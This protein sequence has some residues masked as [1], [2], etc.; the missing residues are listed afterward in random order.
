MHR[1]LPNFY[2]S[3]KCISGSHLIVTFLTNCLFMD[4]WEDTNSEQNCSWFNIGFTLENLWSRQNHLGILIF[5]LFLDQCL[6]QS[7]IRSVLQCVFWW[8]FH[9]MKNTGM[10]WMSLV[11]P[12]VFLLLP[13]RKLLEM[14]AL[15]VY[16]S[17]YMAFLWPV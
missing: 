4:F 11:R 1:I 8:N 14:V 12:N 3:I 13:L 5:C 6:L 2:F 7:I 17:G 9:L 16:L 10:Q 15:L